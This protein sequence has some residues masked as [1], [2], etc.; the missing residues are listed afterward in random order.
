MYDVCSI[1]TIKYNTHQKLGIRILNA[2]PIYRKDRY[3]EEYRKHNGL[4]QSITRHSCRY[5]KHALFVNGSN[6]NF[7]QSSNPSSPCIS[8]SRLECRKMSEPHPGWNRKMALKCYF[9]DQDVKLTAP[10]K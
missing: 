2:S 5:I 6:S 8:K 9:E 1:K 7:G 4:L 3:D 10:I